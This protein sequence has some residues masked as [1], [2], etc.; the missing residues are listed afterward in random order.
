MLFDDLSSIFPEEELFVDP[1]LGYGYHPVA[2]GQLLR[3]SSFRVVRKLGHAAAGTVWLCEKR[4]RSRTSFVAVK[5]LTIYYTKQITSGYSHESAVLEMIQK[6]RHHPGYPHLLHLRRIFNTQSQLGSHMC[7]ATDVLGSS[8]LDLR[9]KQPKMVFTLPVTKR[10]IKQTLL[11]LQLLHDCG[12]VHNDIKT[13]DIV[14]VLPSGHGG[15]LTYIEK[16]PAE[17]YEPLNLPGL[18][19]LPIITVKSQPLPDIGLLPDL[20]NLNVKLIDYGEAQLANAKHMDD[21]QPSMFCPPESILG[22]SWSTPSD[23]WAVGCM[24]FE[25]VGDYHLFRQ[26]NFDNAVHIQQ[27]TERI[28]KIPSTFLV[29]CQYGSRYFDRN[30]DLVQVKDWDECSIERTV[31][32]VSEAKNLDLNG[33]DGFLRACLIWDPRKR[34][35]AAQLLADPWLNGV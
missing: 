4:R 3:P 17:T 25:L 12:F 20:S 1:G 19:S 14:S 2:L 7:F 27:I 23:I 29:D 33:L 30:G 26:D 6:Y 21:S 15:T 24:V 34:S 16:H 32:G 13:N 5:I 31:K 22:F 11:A 35:T 28:G 8:L 18:T 9:M 10:I